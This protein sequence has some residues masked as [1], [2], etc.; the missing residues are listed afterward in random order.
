MSRHAERTAATLAWTGCGLIF[1][2]LIVVLYSLWLPDVT[3]LRDTNP[4]TTKYVRIYV[5]R[6]RRRGDRAAVHMN[7]MPLD[8]ISIHLRR[9]VLIAEDD[10]FFMHQGIDWDAF[11]SA[12]RYNI[13][14]RKM[15]RG[16]STITQQVARNLFLSPSRKARR[17]LKEMLLARHLERSMDKD[18]I[19]EIYLNIVEWGEG[20]FGAEAASRAYYNK[21]AADLTPEEAV[22]LAAS[23]PS[24]YRYNPS[25]EPDARTIAVRAHY[26]KRLLTEHPTQ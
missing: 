20:I 24:P 13:K 23:L 16:A 3:S 7:W 5:E 17:K 12:L 26:L 21:S 18:R 9:A 6:L 4:M 19:L 15:A 2:A 1:V 10:R 25:I 8:R 22:A 14:K 11:E